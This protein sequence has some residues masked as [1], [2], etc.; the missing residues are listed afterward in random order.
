MQFA[1][2]IPGVMDLDVVLNEAARQRQ[3]FVT[4][5]DGARFSSRVLSDGTLRILALLTLL[6]DPRVPDL[7]QPL[8]VAAAIARFEADRSAIEAAARRAVADEDARADVCGPRSQPP[9]M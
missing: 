2:L 1:R 3:V 7:A 5:R 8:D 9:T 6:N 4:M